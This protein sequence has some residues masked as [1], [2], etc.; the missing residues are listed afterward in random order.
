MSTHCWILSSALQGGVLLFKHV[1]NTHK[2]G[3][4]ATSWRHFRTAGVVLYLEMCRK[5]IYHCHRSLYAAICLFIFFYRVFPI[6]PHPQS[7]PQM[8]MCVTGVEIVN[9]TPRR[10]AWDVTWWGGTLALQRFKTLQ[11]CF[12]FKT[13][14]CKIFTSIEPPKSAGLIQ[15]PLWFFFF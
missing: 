14:C 6:I 15:D 1:E 9:K 5:N 2:R 10:P 8:S 7:V 11:F 3:S 12:V 4:M 13:F